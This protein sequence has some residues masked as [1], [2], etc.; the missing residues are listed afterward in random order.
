MENIL[1]PSKMTF[2]EG[3]T[4]NESTIVIEPL[5]H[6]YGTTIGN[7]LRRVLLSSLEGAAVTAVKIKGAQHE[8]A[9]I[10]GVKEDALEII[11]NL[12]KLRLKSHSSEPVVLK[13]DVS[14]K[15]GAVKAEAISANADIEIANPELVIATR[16][17]D[18]ALSMEIT[19]EKGRGFLPTEERDEVATDL[20]KIA[21]DALFS[22]VVNVSLAVENTR[23]GEVTNYDKLIM[24]VKT[25]GTL[26]PQEA[27]QQATKMVLNHFH[28]IEG[29]VSH[30]SLAEESTDS[31]VIQETEADKE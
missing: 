23:V 3:E 27:V 11:L 10:E 18:A 6:G 25:D 31:E 9:T 1:L 4:V 5:H 2:S 21:I 29:Q 22:P 20:G 15:A 12:K 30:G 14:G 19:V 7:A 28:W 24:K 16:T 13:L 26:T 17:S 8:F